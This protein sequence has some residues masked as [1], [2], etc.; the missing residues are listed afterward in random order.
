MERSRKRKEYEARS[1]SILSDAK[2]RRTTIRGT[3]GLLVSRQRA[4][5]GH[6][7]LEDVQE[8]HD[9][10]SGR[11]A[12]C[13][14]HYTFGTRLPSKASIDRIDAS[15]SYS[16]TNSWI[17]CLSC[18]LGKSSWSS[19]LFRS[20]F[21]RNQTTVEVFEER[22]VRRHLAERRNSCRQNIKKRESRAMR[23]E[24][25]IDDLVDMAK[26]QDNKCFYTGHEMSF[27]NVGDIIAASVDR[28]DSSRGYVSGNVVLCCS[29]FNLYKNDFDETEV[30]DRWKA[31]VEQLS[32]S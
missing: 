14:L 19:R 16:R 7:S 10:Q 13:N 9:E 18:N 27:G 26:Q 20:M 1:E 12:L 29:F 5:G 15:S 32:S 25:S 31:A 24:L 21:S 4:K 8:L 30:L 11:C 22:D 2:R 17:T 3:F 28:R 23:F 6:L